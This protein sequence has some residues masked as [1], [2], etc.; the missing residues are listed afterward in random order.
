MMSEGR[1]SLRRRLLVAA[2]LPLLF[3]V[4]LVVWFLS[5]PINP[6]V[7]IVRI[8]PARGTSGLVLSLLGPSGQKL[9]DWPFVDTPEAAALAVLEKRVPWEAVSRNTSVARPCLVLQLGR[10][11]PEAAVPAPQGEV[12]PGA[13][14]V[15]LEAS[16]SLPPATASALLEAVRAV[17]PAEMVTVN[18]V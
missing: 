5:R 13:P 1:P 16:S 3:L 8:V 14:C 18:D 12:A 10:T 2:V 6:G 11:V 7:F 9:G 4:G 17:C 15:R